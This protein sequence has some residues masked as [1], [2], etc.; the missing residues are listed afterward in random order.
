MD[1][2][3]LFDDPEFN[4]ALAGAS[5]RAR[6]PRCPSFLQPL[7]QLLSRLPDEWLIATGLASQPQPVLES[8][9]PGARPRAGDPATSWANVSYSATAVLPDPDQFTS[10]D[11]DKAAVIAN[12]IAELLHRRSAQGQAVRDRQGLRLAR[13]AAG[14]AA[15]RGAE[16]RRGGARSSR[17]RTTSS[18]PAAASLNDQELADLNVQLITARADLADEPGQAA[19]GAR[20]ARLGGRRWSRWATWPARR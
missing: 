16:V 10:P 6:R 13:A 18:R 7:E 19:A 12:R 2:L 14:R 20:P 4:P 1:D 3:N 9:A 5:R 8:E 17:S 15:R 11:P